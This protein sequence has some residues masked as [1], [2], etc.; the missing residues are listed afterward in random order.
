MADLVGRVLAGRYRLLGS[1][2]AGAGGRVYAADD[3]RLRR[4]VAVK[5]LHAGLSDDIGLPAPV[6]H[7]GAARGLAAPPQRHGRLRLGRGRRH[8]VHG[9]RA[10]RRRLAAGDARRRDPAHPVAGR[11]RRPPGRRRRSSTPTA[12]GW[13]TATS[14]PRTSSSTS[15]ASCASPTSASPA[16]SPKRAGPSP[17]APCSA[18][19]AT[20]RRSRAPPGRLDGRADLYA[21]GLVLVESVTGNVPLVAES[22][23]G[24][25]AHPHRAADHRARRSMGALGAVIER[26]GQVGSRRPLSRRA[27]D[28]R[29][30]RRRRSAC[31]RRPARSRS[32]V[33]ARRS[34]DPH[35]TQVVTRAPSRLRPGRERRRSRCRSRHRAAPADVGPERPRHRPAR[36]RARARPRRRG[37]RVRPDPTVDR[38]RRCTVPI[39][40]G[41]NERPGADA[42]RTRS[43]LLV[44]STRAAPR[45]TPRD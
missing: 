18:P 44:S 41:M 34:R 42:R 3:V 26:A 35:P 31:C 38:C 1:I 17:P 19:R 24:T 15:T 6:P 25:L 36:A 27:D 29:R 11:P 9:A 4:R 43:G 12:A 7:R 40:Q 37:R 13:S 28:G 16:R 22:P 20:R 14:S 23:L 10:A 45:T 2:G 33:S 8:P 21:L 32:P 5:V 30:A 39:L